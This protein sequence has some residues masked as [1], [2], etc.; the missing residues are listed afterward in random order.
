MTENRSC[1]C[2]LVY[3]RNFQLENEVYSVL[4]Y[5][6]NDLQIIIFQRSIRLGSKVLSNSIEI[7]I[8]A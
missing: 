6:I 4:E 1:L 2:K 3:G 8:T 5:T 7:F